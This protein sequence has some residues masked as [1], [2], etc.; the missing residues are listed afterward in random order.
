MVMEAV[1]RKLMMMQKN[2]VMVRT[3]CRFFDHHE[4]AKS[5]YTEPL[6]ADHCSHQS[7]YNVKFHATDRVALPESMRSLAVI[8]QVVLHLQGLQA[9]CRRVLEEQ[10]H[11]LNLAT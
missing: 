3:R 9:Q 8:G 11:Q 4:Q 10:C 5:M 7:H 6:P 2:R 1:T